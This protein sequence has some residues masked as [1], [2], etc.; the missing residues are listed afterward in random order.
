MSSNI[1]EFNK[2]LNKLTLVA[3]KFRYRTNEVFIMA[4]DHSSLQIS[5]KTFV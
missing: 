2:L 3:D 1:E 4:R 5:T